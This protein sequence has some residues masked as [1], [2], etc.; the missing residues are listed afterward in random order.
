MKTET[1][2]STTW[3]T[4]WNGNEFITTAISF[5]QMSVK[6]RIQNKLI[7]NPNFFLFVCDFR[8]G[9]ANGPPSKTNRKWWLRTWWRQPLRPSTITISR[10]I[11]ISSTTRN[12]WSTMRTLRIRF[13]RRL[14]VRI[15][16]ISTKK[17]WQLS[18]FKHKFWQ[19]SFWISKF[20]VFGLFVDIK[21]LIREL[22]GL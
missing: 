20:I 10:A 2:T 6:F 22:N 14:S 11:T 7:F 4:T 8:C 1:S 9:P 12:S 16:K 5:I 15:L 21:F 17:I 3:K 13:M 19:L 18:K